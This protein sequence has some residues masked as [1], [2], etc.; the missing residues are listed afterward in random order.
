MKKNPSPTVSSQRFDRTLSALH[1]QA[2]PRYLFGDLPRAQ[3]YAILSRRYFQA[4]IGFCDYA[5]FYLL[6]FFGGTSTCV[7]TNCTSTEEDSTAFNQ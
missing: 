2:Y 3:E 6:R 7:S 1:A 5:V 4:E